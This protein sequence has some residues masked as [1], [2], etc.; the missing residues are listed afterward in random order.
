MPSNAQTIWNATRTA[1]F[2]ELESVHRNIAGGTPGRKWLTEQLDRAYVVALASQFQGFARDLHSEASSFVAQQAPVSIAG[3][4]ESALTLNR[5]LDRGNA[6]PGNLGSD[7]LRFGIDLWP[8]AY[9]L[10]LRNRRRRLALEQVTT[11]RNAIA[12][13]TPIS[14]GSAATVA[15]TRPTLTWCRRW[16]RMLTAL[17]R[18]LDVAVGSHLELLVGSQPW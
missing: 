16:R 9:G 4:V 11:W 3:L 8:A 15:N 7:F 2:D 12:H 17:V 10:D 6:T 5:Y 14:A 18:S 13:D 1:R